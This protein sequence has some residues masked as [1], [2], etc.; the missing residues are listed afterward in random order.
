LSLLRQTGS[1]VVALLASAALT[2]AQ[3]NGA[4]LPRGKGKFSGVYRAVGA[5]EAHTIGWR[6]VAFFPDG[7]FVEGFPPA[8]MD[9]LDEDAEIARNPVGWG[10]YR[11]AGAWGEIT[12]AKTDPSDT[13]ALV[14]KIKE[15][16]DRLLVDGDAYYRLEPCNGLKLEG[17]FRREDYRTTPTAAQGIT[18]A[19][20]GRFVDEGAFQAAGVLV[21]SPS[22]S[23]DDFDDGVPGR[24]AYRIANYTIE[25][26][27]SDGRVKRTSLFMEPG[28]RQ[29]DVRE[30]FL[31]TWKFIRVR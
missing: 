10:T 15:Y 12:F 19:P 6:Y 14:W 11:M 30:F 1:V 2:A 29:T 8:V 23:G 17:T 27:Y 28:A 18:F 9:Q 21:R 24:G 31:N 13:E 20:D 26:R 16:E 7:R 4:S 3:G 5:T 25:L 22:G